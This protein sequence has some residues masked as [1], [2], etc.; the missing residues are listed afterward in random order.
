VP[1][2]VDPTTHD[3]TPAST[4]RLARELAARDGTV[5]VVGH[6]NTVPAAIAALGGPRLEI[7]DKT[8]DDLFVVTLVDGKFAGFA[9]LKYGA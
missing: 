8:F 7:D 9:H 2:E 6:S 3:P 1:A 5:L 4:E